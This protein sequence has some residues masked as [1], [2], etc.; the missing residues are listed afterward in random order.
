MHG[1][2][3]PAK[4][5][6]QPGGREKEDSGRKHLTGREVE[7]LI[8]AAKGGRNEARDR[9]LLLLMFRQRLRGLQQTAGSAGH[10]RLDR[11]IESPHRRRHVWC[12]V[13]S[14]S[15]RAESQFTAFR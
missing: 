11:G 1:R 12:R 5:G 6:R 4:T 7:K 9:C 10:C 14:Q 2:K 13:L 15:P 3:N 8:D